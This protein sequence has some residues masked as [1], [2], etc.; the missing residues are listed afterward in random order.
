M[1]LI[2]LPENW[3]LLKIMSITKDGELQDWFSDD[4]NNDQGAIKDGQN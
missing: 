4:H 2:D 3:K 1:A